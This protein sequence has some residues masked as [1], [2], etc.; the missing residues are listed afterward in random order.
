MKFYVIWKLIPW[1]LAHIARKP[2]THWEEEMETHL[3]FS[4]NL[5]SLPQPHSWAAVACE[6]PGRVCLSLSTG[7]RRWLPGAFYDSLPVS[8]L[9]FTSL[10]G[11]DISIHLHISARNQQD[12][13]RE[14]GSCIWEAF[15]AFLKH[16]KR[17]IQA[18]SLQAERLLGA[19]KRIRGSRALHRHLCSCR[20]DSRCICLCIVLHC[21]SAYLLSGGLPS[22]QC[23][24]KSACHYFIFWNPKML[25][26]FHGKQNVF[27]NCSSEFGKVSLFSPSLSFQQD[28]CLC[29]F[30]FSSFSVV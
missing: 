4:T 3:R 21:F 26:C 7:G 6:S 28:A 20:V 13:S 16:E 15:A 23:L 22:C 11:V 24:T 30:F 19:M 8:W 27:N 17:K 10:P 14:W 18:P 1:P 5:F 12:A 2:S 9:L 25:K 29:S